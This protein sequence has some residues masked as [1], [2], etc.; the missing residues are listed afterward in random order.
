MTGFFHVLMTVLLNATLQFIVVAFV[1]AVCDRL[2]RNFEL[3]RHI[4]WVGALLTCLIFA[5]MA[6]SR[7]FNAAQVPAQPSQ[8]VSSIDPQNAA[9][10]EA[11]SSSGRT[12]PSVPLTSSILPR[13]VRFNVATLAALFVLYLFLTGL[14]M[15]RL[16]RAWFR[17]RK[18]ASNGSPIDWE[19]GSLR[20][21]I[22]RCFASMR[23]GPVQLLASNDP[24]APCAVGWHRPRVILPRRLL[25]EA[26]EK[27]VIAGLGHELAHVLRRDYALNLFYKIVA[28]PFA[29]H[30]AIA[31]ILRRIEE[32]RELCCDEL[33][34]ERLLEPGSYARSLVVFAGWALPAQALAVTVGITDGNFL[35]ERIMTILKNKNSK[36][37]RNWL[38]AAAALA[39][40]LPAWAATKLALNVSVP[41]FTQDEPKK[42]MTDEERA[43]HERK[44]LETRRREENGSPE[45]REKREALAKEERAARDREQGELIKAARVTMDQ[46]V[47]AAIQNT[48][49]TAVESNIHRGK[50][51]APRYM[52]RVL[53][54]SNGQSAY[55]IVNGVTGQVEK[56]EKPE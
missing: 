22:E 37:F 39:F 29:F 38:L 14:Q 43:A 16:V 13:T 8:L 48:P 9:L 33:V 45:E 44:E 20:G 41:N 21:L 25:H 56:V 35:E 18:V 11:S 2:L 34:T 50:D 47:Q 42:Q 24:V 4:L 31:Y 26:D 12:S 1:A 17:A 55:V 23:C 53:Q 6:A 28:L 30:P 5:G 36:R 19:T 46:A 27:L 32:T 10:P 54:T 52:V 3:A 7:S 40:V 49:G 51:G 15:F